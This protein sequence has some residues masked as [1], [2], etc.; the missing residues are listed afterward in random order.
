MRISMNTYL[1]MDSVMPVDT[2]A[3]MLMISGIQCG[4]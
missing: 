1:M 3:Y 2:G 4:L